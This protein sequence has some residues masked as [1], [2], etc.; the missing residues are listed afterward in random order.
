M[1]S[2]KPLG[3]RRNSTKP[4]L[5]SAEHKRIKQR[6]R[7]SEQIFHSLFAF[8]PNAIGVFSP[9]G[10]LVRS[11]PTVTE[12][13]GYSEQELLGKSFS[14][15]LA[16]EQVLHGMSQFKL[17]R[18]GMPQ[19]FDTVLLHKNGYQ[20]EVNATSV[21]ISN[22]RRMTG[23]IVICQDISERKRNENRIRHMAY[24]DDMTGLPNRRY[25]KEKLAEALAAAS[26]EKIAVFYMDIDRFK[27]VNDSFGYD[28][29][30]MLMLQVAERLTR[31]ISA[32]DFLARTEG[33][34]FAIGYT[35]VM[36]A[37]E[38]RRRADTIAKLLEQPFVVGGDS[39]HLSTSI[40]VS[41][42]SGAEEEDA[43][44]LMKY[45]EIALSQSKESGKNNYQ[46]FNQ[47]MKTGSMQRLKMESELRRALLNEEFELF[48]QPQMEVSSGKIV[49]MEALIRWMHP[50][51]GLVPPREFIPVA[52][53]SG[54]IVPIGE[55]VIL[56]ACRQNKKWQE[57]QL[58]YVPVSVN[59]SVRQFLQPS[60]KDKISHI[61]EI[62]GLNPEYLDLE[63]TESMTMDVE[64]ATTNLL[65]LKHLGVQISIDDFGT[66]YSS[67]SYL[68][69]FP[70]DKLKIDYSFVRDI[71]SDPNDAAIVATIIS[72]AHHLHLE[73]IAEGVETK[74]QLKFL[75]H[76]R[77][78]HIQGYWFSPP[79]N[80]AHIEE[81]LRSRPS[82]VS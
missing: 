58:I 14:S 80:V 40:G 30:N 78:N 62:T 29:G 42:F 22:G 61:L 59:L 50:T 53:E 81:L 73:V 2:Q 66:G 44:T 11:N 27:L 51:K 43:E 48:Y 55:W 64:I 54:L 60:L 70:I 15:F 39:I 47:A 68:K 24:Y 17:A 35:G 12:L 71:M 67:L 1:D 19:T 7:D 65:E 26:P 10:I 4:A 82:E 20:I 8:N 25:F 57:E 9:S 45:A 23:F 72:M 74:E 36:S 56:E 79:V 21:P 52:E 13:T 38:L 28:Y 46:V 3:K 63:I 16:P 18:N 31:C 6:L 34:E 49:G 41:L 5:A 77:C 32:D 37:E 69:K 33:D 76:N 75:D